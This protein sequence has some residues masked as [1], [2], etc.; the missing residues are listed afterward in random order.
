MERSSLHAI[1]TEKRIYYL[2]SRVTAAPYGGESAPKE[3]QFQKKFNEFHPTQLFSAFL[4]LII[5]PLRKEN[6][7]KVQ[8]GTKGSADE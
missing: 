2:I 5:E 3:G 8:N 1:F 7:Q 4:T 6:T